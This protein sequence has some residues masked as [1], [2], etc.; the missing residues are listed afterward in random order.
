MITTIIGLP[1]DTMAAGGR[2]GAVAGVGDTAGVG[3]MGFMAELADSTVAGFMV[4][5][6]VVST[7]VGFMAAA[8][9]MEVGDDGNLRVVVKG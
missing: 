1:T 6:A 2:Y 4:A 5:S 3:I 7:E 9:S 8:D